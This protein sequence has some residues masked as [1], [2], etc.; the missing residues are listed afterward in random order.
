MGRAS[1]AGQGPAQEEGEPAFSRPPP[2]CW[3]PLRVAGLTGSENC[4]PSAAAALLDRLGRAFAGGSRFPV[5]GLRS[6]GVVGVLCS[7]GHTRR[8]RAAAGIGRPGCCRWGRGWPATSCA[9][10]QGEV[11][12]RPSAGWILAPWRC[13]RSA[14]R[15]GADL[16]R[17]ARH[18]LARLAAL[19]DWPT[20]LHPCTENLR[21]SPCSTRWLWQIATRQRSALLIT[22]R[23]GEQHIGVD[24]EPGRGLRRHE[25]SEIPGVSAARRTRR[26]A[27]A[28]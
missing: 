21:M 26:L 18:W 5:P 3:G 13:D 23:P 2:V 1:R 25:I 7:Y 11:T 16:A 6:C 12:I 22:G 19:G 28:V 17:P 24:V 4:W 14:V 27:L 10:F 8:R 15:G 9:R 20:G